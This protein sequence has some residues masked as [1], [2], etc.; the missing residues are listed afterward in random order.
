M[1]YYGFT[2]PIRLLQRP[3]EQP[4]YPAIAAWTC[5]VA[6]YKRQKTEDRRQKKTKRRLF[7]EPFNSP[8]EKFIYPR[9]AR[10]KNERA[11]L[12]K[13]SFPIRT[14]DGCPEPVLVK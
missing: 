14:F 13:L 11:L 12:S 5:C 8:I 6:E 1:V 7:F 10:D 4:E 2:L 3:T 9:Q